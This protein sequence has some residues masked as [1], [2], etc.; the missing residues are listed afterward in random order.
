MANKIYI[1]Y[2]FLNNLNR[3]CAGQCGTGLN[4]NVLEP[5][6]IMENNIKSVALGF[7]EK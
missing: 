1:T 5:T 4:D 7:K 6:L 3:N 2:L